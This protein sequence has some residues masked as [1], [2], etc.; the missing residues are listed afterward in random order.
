MCLARL[1]QE[2]N[3]LADFS[4]RA[5]AH[6]N[7]HFTWKQVA[8]AVDELYTRVLAARSAPLTSARPLNGDDR[9]VRL[10]HAFADRLATLARVREQLGPSVL[11]AAE[12]LS[13]GLA[14]GHKVLLC[15]NGGSA[16]DVQHF[17]AELVGRFQASDRRALPALALTADTAVLTAW[18]N[19]IG[20]E[21]VFA[22]QV[23]AF[24]QPGD[25]L[26]G[27]STSGRSHNLVRAFETAGQRGLTRIALVGGD[28][29]PLARLADA[30]I[31]VPCEDTQQIQE[32]QLMVI[33]LL[34]EL[35]ETAV[36]AQSAELQPPV[37]GIWPDR[38]YA[39]A[40]SSV[41]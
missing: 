39:V 34:C 28:G 17:A 11:E 37:D 16:A 38:A 5:I 2:P 10:D 22:R 27:L 3:L 9:L 1:Y 29:G 33:H 21:H 30:A 31:I 20:F 12:L 32:M 8:D 18:A 26:L 41:Q 6:V 35:A 24:G 25:V 14:R 13:A 36:L 7:A 4:R 40:S 19:D 15:G 23:E